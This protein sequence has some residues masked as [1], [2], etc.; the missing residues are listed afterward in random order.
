MHHHCHNY[1]LYKCS[2]SVF[3]S[4]AIKDTK[5]ESTETTHLLKDTDVKYTEA[6]ETNDVITVR[7]A[8]SMLTQWH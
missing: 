7:G 5:E 8:A 1:V 6:T 3:V 2:T 4:P